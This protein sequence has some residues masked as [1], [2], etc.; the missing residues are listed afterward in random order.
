MKLKP[1]FKIEDRVIPKGTKF[2][3]TVVGVQIINNTF[4]Y[5]I[6]DEFDIYDFSEL[7]LESYIEAK[8]VEMDSDINMYKWHSVQDELPTRTKR[9]CV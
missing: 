8:S 2:I 6:K 4:W 9:F 5:K 1:K 7:E 3:M